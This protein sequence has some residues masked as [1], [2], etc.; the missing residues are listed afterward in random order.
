[1]TFKKIYDITHTLNNNFPVWPGDPPGVIQLDATIENGDKYNSS[2]IRSSLHWGTHVDAPAHLYQDKLTIDQLSL[3]LLIGPAKV[4]HF[5]EAMQITADLLQPIN[6]QKYQRAL[7][8]TRNSEFWNTPEPAFRTDF[9]ALTEDAA[10]HLVTNGIKLVGIDYF[11]LD[12]FEA[13]G[14]P[15]HKILYQQNIIGL[16]GLD[17]REISEGDYDLICL[18]VKIGRGDGAPAR[19]LLL[20]K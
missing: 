1:M 17:L 4:I 5:P 13:N 14:L 10:I 9:T 19:V 12:L 7:F 6:I 18:P 15:V 2:S 11:S 3:D 20:E 8:K 16:E